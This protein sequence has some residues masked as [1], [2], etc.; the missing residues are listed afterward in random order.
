MNRLNFRKAIFAMSF[1]MTFTLYFGCHDHPDDDDENIVNP[2][3]V[4]SD[5]DGVADFED[6]KP[7][8]PFYPT[9]PLTGCNDGD[10]YTVND[11]IQLD[12]CT[13]LGECPSNLVNLGQFGGTGGS[14]KDMVVPECGKIVE[15]ITRSGDRLDYLEVVYEL[16]GE[17]HSI[18]AGG[19]GGT[20][21]PPFKITAPISKISL[22][23]G[24]RIDM[25]QIHLADGKSSPKYGGTGGTPAEV[26]LGN[27]VFRGFNVRAGDEIDFAAP[28]AAF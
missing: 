20:L 2:Q 25:L 13:C 5:G 16:N 6:C 21:N 12:G 17:R 3:I 26:S 24:D 11:Q 22:R 10:F 1:I 27:M 14:P 19:G 28:V 18:S 9:L 8:D 4:D 7:N 23:H 15:I